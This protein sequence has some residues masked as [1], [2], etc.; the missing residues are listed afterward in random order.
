MVCDRDGGS[1]A[2]LCNE[3]GPIVFPDFNFYSSKAGT[4]ISGPYPHHK[5]IVSGSGGGVAQVAS[6]APRYALCP[7]KG[8]G[9]AQLLTT[10]LSTDHLWGG[11]AKRGERVSGKPVSA[12]YCLLYGMDRSRV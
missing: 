10:S 11:E 4:Q 2:Q 8:L 12:L 6:S 5:T 7:R 9:H 3:T 1:S